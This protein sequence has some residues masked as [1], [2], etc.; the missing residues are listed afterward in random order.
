VG[1][2]S[3]S[4]GLAKN[5]VEAGEERGRRGSERESGTNE[6][7]NDLGSVPT[8]SITGLSHLT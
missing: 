5:N 3:I 7:G 1:R 2:R 4:R 6:D 8:P